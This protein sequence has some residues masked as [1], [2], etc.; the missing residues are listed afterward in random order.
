MANFLT[1]YKSLSD[2]E[3]GANALILPPPSYAS[4]KQT[5]ST[6]VNSGRASDGVLYAQR[7]LDRDLVKLEIGWKY[8]TATQWS[9][10]LQQILGET[11]DGFY[12]YITYFDMSYNTFRC[13]QFYPSDRTATPFKVDPTTKAVL[14]WLDCGINFI[15][16]GRA[17]VTV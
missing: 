13:L 14:S 15:D 6:V 4:G 11:G 2:A 8:L 17:E 16:T 9:S 3:A 1:M 10:I 5:A 7:V 12:V